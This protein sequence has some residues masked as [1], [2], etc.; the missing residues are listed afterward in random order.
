MKM[1]GCCDT[2]NNMNAEIVISNLDMKY[3]KG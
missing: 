1:I 3:V 2:E